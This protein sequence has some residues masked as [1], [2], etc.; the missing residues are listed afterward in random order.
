MDQA[1]Q[2]T[3]FDWFQYR[4]V[5]DNE[6]FPS[7][8]QRELSVSMRKYLQLLRIEPGQTL[9]FPDGTTRQVT[10]DW[11]IQQYRELRENGTRAGSSND[12]EYTEDNSYNT[13][14]YQRSVSHDSTEHEVTDRDTSTSGSYSD[15]SRT[16][17]HGSD[18]SSSNQNSDAITLAKASPQSISYPAATGGAPNGLDWTYPSSQGENKGSTQTANSGSNQNTTQT[19]G[20]GSNGSTSGE[21]VDR[22]KTYLDGSTEDSGRTVQ[23]STNGSRTN[24]SSNAE[25]NDRKV[26]EAGRQI[27]PA[28]LLQ[29]A[30]EF[31]QNSSAW[32][33][34]YDRL[35]TCFIGIYEQEV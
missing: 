7:F 31:I 25:T 12:V 10:Y 11:M 2:Q 35:D 1:L 14:V 23:G 20:S 15:S 21:D 19:N 5:N 30:V 13:D 26:M 3:I 8:F 4:E 18:S 17:S 34:L 6:R 22:Q 28:T 29:N 9:T 33:F 24:N 16:D 32:K 27:D